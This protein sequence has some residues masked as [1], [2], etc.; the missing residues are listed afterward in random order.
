MPMAVD[1]ATSTLLGQMA[2]SGAKPLHE[3]TPEEARGF[4]GVLREMY[5]PGPEVGSVEDRTDPG[6]R[7]ATSRS[8]SSRRPARPRA[9]IVYYH[10]GG[11]VIGALDEF[12]TLG[13]AAR[14]AH[15]GCTVVLVDY[16]LAPE[17]R[18]PAAADDA[19]TALQWVAGHVGELAHERRAADRRRRQRRRQPRRRR[20]PAGPRRRRPG[21]R[22][23][24]A[25]LPGHRRRPRQRDLLRPGATSCCSPAT[26][27]SGSGTTTPRTPRDR[28]PA[29]RLAAAGRGPVRAAARGRAHRRARR[30][31]RRGRGLRRGARE[32][33]RAGRRTRRFDGQMHGFFT[34]LNVLPG[35]ARGARARRRRA[36]RAPGRYGMTLATQQV[37]AVVVGAGFAGLYLLHRL[38]ELGLSVQVFEAGDGVGGTWY[39]NRYPGARC[40]VESMSYSYSFSPELEQEWEWSEKYPTQPEILRY[41][42]HVADRFDLRRDITFD[43]RV[44]S[45]TTTRP[46]SR[47]TVRTDERRRRRRP[48]PDHGHRLPV[49]APRRR[50]CPGVG[51]LP[52]PDLPHRA[53]AARGRRLHR[54]A[55]RGHRHRLAPASSRSRSSPSRPP[56]SPSSSAPRTSA[57]RPATGRCRRGRGRDDE[58][59]ATASGAR[60]SARP[61]SACRCE[62]A[63]QSALEVPEE[64]RRGALPGRLGPGQPR[65]ASSA[66]Y[67]DT[68]LD[69]AGQR[70]GGRV[71]PGQDPRHRPR[72]RGRRDARAAQLPVRHQAP[73]PRH[74]LL[75]DLQPPHV[76]LV[77][78]RKTPIAE[79]TETGIR[80]SEQRVRRRRHRLRH[81]L[82]RDDRRAHRG[83]HPRPRRARR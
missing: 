62:P 21:D 11:W 34:M 41:L 40:D 2:E 83:R 49:G 4:G 53:L 5:G 55:G 1:A 33:R 47:W 23:A 80:T 27:W 7:T 63:T 46:R 44:T 12:D 29:R 68:L 57:C 16:R 10:G 64:E 77:D 35:A 70:H 6:R 48:V 72:P 17:H 60:P 43:T 14:P 71:R 32:G 59:P 13:P 8:A 82:R 30:A 42:N 54:Q 58:G 28:T 65:R 38:R 39:W 18:Y 74:R 9:V 66:R 22:P 20:R 3:M 36:R 37:D 56:T 73:V 79:I 67:T 75:R 26:R 31:A 19:W 52:G 25:R 61:A 45:A 15:R 24:G 81:R 50:R 76:H 51:P 78:L 69:K